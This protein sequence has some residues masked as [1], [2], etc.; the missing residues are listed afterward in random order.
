L[1][2][3]SSTAAAGRIR[4]TKRYTA[5]TIDW[6]AVYDR[7]SDRCYYCPASELGAGRNYLHLRL[8]PARN[9]QVSG[10]RL[11]TDYTD[12]DLGGMEPAGLEPATS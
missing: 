2:P 12:P 6:I 1:P 8:A 10:I 3:T 4:Q 9:G 11:A 5:A 7:T